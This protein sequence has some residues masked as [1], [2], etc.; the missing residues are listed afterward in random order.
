MPP[1]L[2][3][4]GEE[5]KIRSSVF[6][7][8]RREAL[9]GPRA[10]SGEAWWPALTSF[11]A[12]GQ[13]PSPRLSA[14][15]EVRPLPAPSPKA[16]GKSPPAASK[17]GP[18]SQWCC[19]EQDC[20]FIG[21]SHIRPRLLRNDRKFL[22]R[23]FPAGQLLCL[24]TKPPLSTPH[25]EVNF[26][27]AR[28]SFLNQHP[29]PAPHPHPLGPGHA[30]KPPPGLGNLWEQI[31]RQTPVLTQAILWPYPEGSQVASHLPT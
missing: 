5:Q 6:S 17:A 29:L 15:C 10:G 3:R 16:P 23:Q 31:D 9:L 18:G 21:P 25:W 27:S 19:G 12:L 7:E 28:D 22:G 11:A 26:K 4:K 30:L 13:P 1:Y 8:K 14:L 20:P 24:V 2:N